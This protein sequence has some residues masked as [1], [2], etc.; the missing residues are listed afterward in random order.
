MSFSVRPDQSRHMR[1]N[2]LGILWLE[3]IGDLRHSPADYG[4]TF[5]PE[6]AIAHRF[7]ED[8]WIPVAYEDGCGNFL[9][10]DLAP[11]PG[12]ISGQVIDFGADICDLGVLAPSWGEFLL[13]YAKLLESGVL[14]E[15]SSDTD[16]WMDEF[17]PVFG[18]ACLDALVLWA[19]D[20][21]WPIV[22]FDESWRTADVM[23]VATPST[24]RATSRQ[25]QSWRTPCESQVV[26]RRPSSTIVATPHANT[27][28]GAG[29]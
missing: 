8:N 22:D 9:A 23:V 5:Y 13:S 19:M 18:R 10:V 3:K 7:Y 27:H 14:T 21:R 4:Y 24:K 26:N 17:Y 25:C 11:G 6:N 1:E 16:N 29:W 28:K 20:G 15:I 2:L 12:G